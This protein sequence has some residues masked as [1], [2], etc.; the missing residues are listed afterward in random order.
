MLW[1]EH[2]AG[3]GLYYYRSRYYDAGTGRFIT[4]DPLCFIA[5]DANL[6]RYVH[7]RPTCLTDPTGHV[8]AGAIAGCMAKCLVGSF[9]DDAVGG[10]LALFNKTIRTFVM[11]W[12]SVIAR[13]TMY[14]FI[15]FCTVY[16]AQEPPH[17][18]IQD[19]FIYPIG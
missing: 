19:I 1:R 13:V 7:N 8:G 16:C 2:T 4:R 18:V 11:R 9:G 3:S 12:I 14:P 17:P 6:S 5:G 10:L 15:A